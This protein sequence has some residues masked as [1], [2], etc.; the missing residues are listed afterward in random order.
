M[1][2]TVTVPALITHLITNR[3]G[4]PP[5]CTQI[6]WVALAIDNSDLVD[7]TSLPL[8]REFVKTRYVPSKMW[9]NDWVGGRSPLS[10]PLLA[11]MD[12]RKLRKLAKG[13]GDG[14]GRGSLME[15][16][17]VPCVCP[18]SSHQSAVQKN[19]ALKRYA[20]TVPHVEMKDAVESELDR[21]LK[22]FE[23]LKK[24]KPQP[25]VVNKVRMGRRAMK[26]AAE[27]AQVQ[28]NLKEDEKKMTQLEEKAV[29]RW[30]NLGSMERQ[31]MIGMIAEDLKRVGVPEEDLRTLEGQEKMKA[32]LVEEIRKE[33]EI[34]E[35]LNKKLKKDLKEEETEKKEDEDDEEDE[36]PISERLL[37]L[38]DSFDE[39]V[40]R[41]RGIISM[42]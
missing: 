14:D 18:C 41:L 4:L 36:L 35:E 5:F 11:G 32:I 30:N 28:R 10:D 37:N 2:E 22:E 9:N 3:A 12:I 38:A 27:A 39:F 16:A 34:K 33:E 23:E 6:D 1:M 13:S 15:A 42:P 26:K 25:K 29:E 24:K 40:E 20:A 7:M 17:Y 21:T 19:P 8:T 31:E